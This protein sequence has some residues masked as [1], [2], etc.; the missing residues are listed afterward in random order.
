[1]CSANA[2]AYGDP[3]LILK[4]EIFENSLQSID[5]Q[6]RGSAKEQKAGEMRSPSLENRAKGSSERIGVYF[7]IHGDFRCVAE[8]SRGDSSL[9]G[10]KI[11]ELWG[12]GAA[13]ALT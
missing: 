11:F 7:N 5:G 10:S 6:K 12:W 13:P 9:G 1:M 8:V 4:Y 2:E 3:E